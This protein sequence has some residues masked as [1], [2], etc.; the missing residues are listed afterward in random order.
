MSRPL[1]SLAQQ[2]CCLHQPYANRCRAI[3]KWPM[4]TLTEEDAKKG[5][6]QA[7]QSG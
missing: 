4:Q 7:K 1:V 5:D 2:G 3:E 6:L